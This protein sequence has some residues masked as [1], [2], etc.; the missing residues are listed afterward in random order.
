[1]KE[2]QYES[3]FSNL[4]EMISKLE[5]NNSKLTNKIKNIE[6]INSDLSQKNK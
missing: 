2:N 3:K 5:E 6:L 4:E 1:M